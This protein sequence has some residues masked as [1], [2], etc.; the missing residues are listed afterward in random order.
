MTEASLA[1]LLAGWEPATYST[2][3][4]QI[5]HDEALTGTALEAQLTL[6]MATAWLDQEFGWAIGQDDRTLDGAATTSAEV[7]AQATAIQ[8]ASEFDT[9][10]A[11]SSTGP[12]AYLPSVISYEALAPA[13]YAP[14]LAPWRKVR[15]IRSAR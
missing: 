1:E 7:L 10:L 5:Y 4:G 12:L 8:Q 14:L 6:T 3:D 11:T 9:A 15:R 13:M 2:T